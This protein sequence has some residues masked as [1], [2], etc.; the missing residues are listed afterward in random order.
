VGGRKE[1]SLG[2]SPQFGFRPHHAKLETTQ[3]FSLCAS[4]FATYI[5]VK[6]SGY[7]A[8]RPVRQPQTKDECLHEWRNAVAR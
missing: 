6:N 1:S 4:T 7:F 5:I 3:Y 2:Y 8:K